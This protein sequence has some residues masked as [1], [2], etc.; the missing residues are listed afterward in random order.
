LA[1]ASPYAS[2]GE[3]LIPEPGAYEVY[4]SIDE[5]QPGEIEGAF[6]TC[7]LVAVPEPPTLAMMLLG[8]IGLGFAAKRSSWRA[9]L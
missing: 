2:H 3:L 8:F 7:R 1:W 5:Y 9:V 4:S 6:A